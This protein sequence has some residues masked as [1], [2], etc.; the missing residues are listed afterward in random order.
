[1]DF[2]FFENGLFGGVFHTLY[3]KSGHNG[4]LH[5]FYR[6]FKLVLETRGGFLSGCSRGLEKKS[7]ESEVDSLEWVLEFLKMVSLVGF[8]TH[9][10]SKVV[11]MGFYMG[12][13]DFSNLCWKHGVFF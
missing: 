4:I 12:F 8:S 10:T 11:T 1:M 5:G 9:F 2:G 7:S 6:L 3:L 13:T